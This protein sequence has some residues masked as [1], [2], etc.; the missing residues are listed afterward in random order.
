MIGQTSPTPL[1]RPTSCIFTTSHTGY[2]ILADD[3][4]NTYTDKE[5]CT[6]STT[7]PIKDVTLSRFCTVFEERS[8]GSTGWKHTVLKNVSK[9]VGL[10]NKYTF[11]EY[12]VSRAGRASCRI[13]H[14]DKLSMAYEVV[15]KS[16]NEAPLTHIDVFKIIYIVPILIE[17]VLRHYNFRLRYDVSVIRIKCNASQM[18]CIETMHTTFVASVDMLPIYKLMDQTKKMFVLLDGAGKGMSEIDIQRMI[19][20][21]ARSATVVVTK[22]MSQL[23]VPPRY[24][25][26][27]PTTACTLSRIMHSSNHSLKDYIKHS[28][29]AKDYIKHSEEAFKTL[30][31]A[32]ETRGHSF[33]MLKNYI[34]NH[35]THQKGEDIHK[36]EQ[37]QITAR[38]KETKTDPMEAMYVV[39]DEL[40]MAL[41]SNPG[42]TYFTKNDMK[43]EKKL[44][45]DVYIL[46]G[47][48]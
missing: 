46:K 6:R 19:S 15:M 13:N 12:V 26:F 17:S 34:F 22:T 37:A 2:D 7:I 43:L 28:E 23:I 40:K 31:R 5:W 36:H 9:A 27:I 16:Q 45:E 24:V 11:S 20:A 47:F 33:E 32:N 21:F 8:K 4:S 25:E 42:E 38:I 3:I 44:F 41:R 39:C 48:D 1:R 10:G 29:K 30:A 35:D 14:L 18:N